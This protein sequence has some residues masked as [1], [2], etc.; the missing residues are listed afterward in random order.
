MPL[1]KEY[2]YADEDIQVRDQFFLWSIWWRIKGRKDDKKEE[3]LSHEL[4]LLRL[5][6]PMKALNLKFRDAVQNNL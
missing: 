4:K 1:V 6:K 5:A 2:N 3:I